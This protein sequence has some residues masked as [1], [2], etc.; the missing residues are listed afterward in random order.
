M[1]NGKR[2]AWV[3]KREAEDRQAPPFAR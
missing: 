3:V 2:V 1:E